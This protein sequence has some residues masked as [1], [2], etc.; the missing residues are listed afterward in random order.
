M[1]YDITSV[2][3]DIEL[4]LIKSMRANMKRHIKEEYDEGINWSQWQAEMLAGLSQY[5]AENKEVL[6]DYMGRI[7][8]EIDAAIRE[9]YATGES[10]QEIELLKAIKK[11]YQAPKTGKRATTQG[12]FFR[13]N[14][15]KLNALIYAVDGD[16]DKAETAMLRMVDDVYRQTIF[17][18]QMFY[19]TGAGNMWQCVD[20]ATKDFLSAGINCIEYKNGARVNIVSYSEM[21]LRTANK[22]ANLMGQAMT[23]EKYGVHTVKVNARGIACPMCLQWLDKVYIDDVYGGGTTEESAKSGY[24]LLS[25]AVEG[26]LYHPNCKDSCSTY[27]E[28]ISREPKEITEEQKQETLRRYNLEQKQRY[29]ERNYKRNMRLGNGCLDAGNAQMYFKRANQ[30]K[31]KLIDLCNNNS[32]VLRYDDARIKLRGVLRVDDVGRIIIPTTPQNATQ[33]LTDALKEK[34]KQVQHTEAYN[35]IVNE[36]KSMNVE[37]RKVEL[38]KSV[39]TDDEII[40]RLGGGDMTNGSCSSLALAYAGNKNGFD[41]LDFRGGESQAFFSYKYN[42]DM[43]LELNGV[44]GQILEVKKEAFEIAKIIKELPFDKEY[45]L[46]AGRHAAVI[47]NTEKGLMYL[48]L[49]SINDNGWKYFEYGNITVQDTLKNRFG[50][51][52]NAVKA[53]NSG[54]TITL[55]GKLIEVDSFKDNEEFREILGYINTATDKQKKGASGS[56]K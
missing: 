31:S 29:Y 37:H 54:N 26:G 30:Y 44:K 35:S 33:S 4:S 53:R 34:S 9:A 6:K 17:K 56:V 40:K 49:Q 23:R 7:N 41:V 19:N 16:M 14:Q 15:N 10:E 50:C 20:M 3:E 38:L 45:I 55:K 18:A 27:Y 25:T 21:A 2:F 52:K 13:N 12:A 51:R 11:G 8:A 22:R 48:E 5:R 47:K 43:L 28:G 32:D 46:G 24:P 1:A 42:T 36:L 39:L